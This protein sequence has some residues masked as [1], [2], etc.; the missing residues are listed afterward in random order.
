MVKKLFIIL[1]IASFNS[2]TNAQIATI[3]ADEFPDSSKTRIGI[4]SDYDINSNAFT[5]TFISKFYLGGYIDTDLK[6]SVLSRTK[7]INRIGGNL[8]NGIFAA[9]N[10]EST[11]HNK[12]L[13]FFISVRDRLHFDSQF[14]SDLYKVAFYGNIQFAGETANFNDF[15]LNLIHYQQLQIGLFSSKLDSAAR[16]G[17]GLSFLK[18]QQ[19]ISVLAKKAELFTSDDGQYINFNTQLNAT[20][21]NPAQS[22]IGAMNGFGT[23]LDIYF[24]APFQTRSGDSKLR[25]AVSDIGFIHFNKQ[26]ETLKQDSLFHYTGITINNIYDIK[27][28]SIGSTSKDSIIKAVA[29]F[30]KEAYN[31]TLPSVLDLTFETHFSKRFHLIEGLRQVFN[32]NYKVMSYIKAHYYFTPNFMLSATFGYGGYGNFNYGLSIFTN[33]GKGFL[34]YAGSNNIEGFIAPKKTTGQGAYITLVKRFK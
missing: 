2:T 5:N 4:T 15:S 18:G 17:I 24:E 10:L 22:G 20:Q 19:Y 26:T 23:S 12:N 3:F 14:S 33:L 28:A 29:P 11:F 1:F 31:A 8:N 34:V 16:W 25:V 30:Q 27:D 9:F 21:S 13:N 7:N 6:N 32:G